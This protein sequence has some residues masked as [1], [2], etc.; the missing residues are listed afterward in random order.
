MIA[1]LPRLLAALPAGILPPGR[2]VEPEDGGAPAY[3]L[4]D[5]PVEPY[6]W[7][8]LRRNHHETGLWPLLLSGLT[9]E[10]S[11]PWVDG[12]VSPARM[13]SPDRHDVAELLA[14][15]WGD[16][17]EVHEDDMLDAA[18]RV[19][20]TAPF[21]QRWPGLAA[22][23]EP[24]GPVGD[25][26]DEYAGFLLDG[27]PRL[28]LVAA[29]R[30]ADTLAVAGWTGPTNHIGDAG[31]V[32]AVVRSWEDR[33]GVRVVGVGF[34]TLHLSVAAPPTTREHA[35]HVAAEHFAFCPDNIWQGVGSLAE[36]ADEIREMNSW[37]FWWD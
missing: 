15:W 24:E 35:L 8:Q 13:S 33:F 26:A 27:R 1:D 6:L 16:G 4:S 3:W 21:G 22:P 11:R 5:A 28:G 18:E 10:E 32:S 30:S 36:Y 25:F 12:E 31:R 20:V 37:S 34:D 23:G 14:G 19:E 17:T 29:T 2:L 9:R 7:T